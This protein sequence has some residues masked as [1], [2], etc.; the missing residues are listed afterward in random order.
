MSTSYDK[1]P[2]GEEIDDS[3]IDFSDLREQ[4]EVR[5]EEGLDTF[6]VLDGLPKTEESK[7]E[8]LKKFISRKLNPVG[9]VRENGFHMPVAADGKTEG[10]VLLILATL[11]LKICLCRIYHRQRGRSRSQ[12]TR[13]NSTGQEASHACQQAHRC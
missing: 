12:D 8:Q 2:E 4:Y 13:Q 3:E 9:R 1:L 6:V 5:V 11:T 7:V 10:Y